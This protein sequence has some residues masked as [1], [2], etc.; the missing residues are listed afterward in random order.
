MFHYDCYHDGRSFG[1]VLGDLWRV[2][3][4]SRSAQS[5]LLLPSVACLC[6]HSDDIAHNSVLG[7]CRGSTGCLLGS[8]ASPTSSASLIT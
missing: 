5:T 7:M 2:P 1:S 3:R 4:H 6:C 8:V